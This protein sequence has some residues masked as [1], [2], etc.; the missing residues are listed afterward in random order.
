[1]AMVS[2]HLLKPHQK[3]VPVFFFH[4]EFFF[5]AFFRPTPGASCSNQGSYHSNHPACSPPDCTAW[6]GVAWD[7]NRLEINGTSAK[8]RKCRKIKTWRK[9]K[10]VI[11]VR[12]ML[13]LNVVCILNNFKKKIYIY[14]YTCIHLAL[15]CSQFFC[16]PP[17]SSMGFPNHQ[18]HMVLD[19]SIAS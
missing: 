8:G 15:R 2:V 11:F 10:K 14:I 16:G 6:R 4:T 18:A 19:I 17:F 5:D 3:K 9:E 12:L 1:M 13:T 7:G